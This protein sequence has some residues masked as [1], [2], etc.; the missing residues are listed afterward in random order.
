MLIDLPCVDD[1]SKCL[2]VK[3]VAFSL[4]QIVAGSKHSASFS[5]DPR[6]EHRFNIALSR[7]LTVC[8]EA[9]GVDACYL[10]LRTAAAV[11]QI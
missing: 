11:F 5:D 6:A 7:I 2:Y 8:W 9:G 10:E 3:D 4:C 1:V